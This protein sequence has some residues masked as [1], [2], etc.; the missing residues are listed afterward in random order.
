M[1]T[2]FRPNH[3]E[4]LAIIT[5]NADLL[6]ESDLPE[7]LQ[8]FAAHVASYKAVFARWDKGDFSQHTAVL[9]YPTDV[10]GRYLEQSFKTLKARQERLL[11]TKQGA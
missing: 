9:N 3:E 2:V 11:G 6:I 5:K 7:P 10:L 1:Q 4:M 8:L